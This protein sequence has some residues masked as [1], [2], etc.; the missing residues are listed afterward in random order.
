M[1]MVQAAFVAV[2][3]ILGCSLGMPMCPASSSDSQ[4]PA[5]SVVQLLMADN[6]A[7]CR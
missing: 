2:A 6:L 3:V 7:V 4:C 1:A 5:V